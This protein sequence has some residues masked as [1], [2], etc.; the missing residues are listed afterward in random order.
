MIVI[1]AILNSHSAYIWFKTTSNI[2]F[3][4]YREPAF[5]AIKLKCMCSAFAND[6][7]SFGVIEGIVLARGVSF[8]HPV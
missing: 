6:L 4:L 3:F 5:T 2:S 1:D 7:P 8:G